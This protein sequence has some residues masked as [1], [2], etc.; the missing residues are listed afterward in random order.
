MGR[1]DKY[2]THVEPHLKDISEWLETMTEGQIAKRLGI[3]VCSFEKYKTEHPELKEALQAGNEHLADQL[4]STLKKKAMGYYYKETRKTVQNKGKEKVVT[5][6]EV[7]RYAHPDTGAIHLLL[8]NI[9]KDWRNDDQA[10]ID[11]KRRQVEV[12][13]RKQDAQDWGTPEGSGDGVDT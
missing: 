4:K 2:K 6:E 8:K 5:I 9:D 1:K 7:E 3:S 13:E 12:A 11:I 10:T